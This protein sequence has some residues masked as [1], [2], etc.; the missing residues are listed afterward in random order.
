MVFQ[1][2]RIAHGAVHFQ[3]AGQPGAVRRQPR[4]LMQRMTVG[5]LVLLQTPASHSF[6]RWH[7]AGDAIIDSERGM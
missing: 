4:H 5:Q 7:R 3:R 1:D 6:Q 2:L